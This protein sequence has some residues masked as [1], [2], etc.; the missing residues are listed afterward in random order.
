[1]V[2]LL[3]VVLQAV[4]NFWQD[5]STG[6]I[7]DSI[8]GMLP[9]EVTVIRNGS[10]SRV[11]AADL[12]P[13]D[14]VELALGQKVP[15]D[16][17][18]LNG[19]ADLKFD[20][21]ILTGENEPIAFKMENT[22]DNFLETRNVALQ[23]TMVVSGSGQ[24]VVIQTGCAPSRLRRRCTEADSLVHIVTSLSLVA[25]ASSPPSQNLV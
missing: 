10:T 8:S 17:R 7:L 14:L 5:F 13:G 4:F 6:R 19:S 15:A 11:P 21:S 23:G 20:R 12:V 3:V 24:G 16:L 22:S 9:A 18:L 2:I 1:V 25:S